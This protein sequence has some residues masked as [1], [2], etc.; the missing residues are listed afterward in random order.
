VLY[1]M[2]RPGKTGRV[3]LDPGTLSAD[4]TTAVG[5]VGVS[6][7]GT[8]LAYAT[9]EGGSDWLTWRVRAARART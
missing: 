6:D 4:G 7:D 5:A 1:I 2:D 9:S 8:L 3:L